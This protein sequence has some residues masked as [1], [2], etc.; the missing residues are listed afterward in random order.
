MAFFE[1]ILYIPRDS[2]PITDCCSVANYDTR[3]TFI[4]IQN[5][6]AGKTPLFLGSDAASKKD[7]SIFFPSTETTLQWYLMFH[8]VLFSIPLCSL[9]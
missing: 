8:L 6:D 9:S 3:N 7:I 5:A 2:Y 1:Y 4:D